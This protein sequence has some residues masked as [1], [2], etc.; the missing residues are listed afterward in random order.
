[1]DDRHRLS[2][3]TVMRFDLSAEH[4]VEYI[5]L[6]ML[7]VITMFRAAR[8]AKESYGTAYRISGP[9]IRHKRP[10]VTLRK[11]LSL[12]IISRE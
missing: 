4:V 6:T 1:M 7:F 2:N 10:L 11:N 3:S 9:L 5:G 12:V 8:V